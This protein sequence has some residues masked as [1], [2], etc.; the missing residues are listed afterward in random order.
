M[1]IVASRPTVDTTPRLIASNLVDPQSPSGVSDAGTQVFWIQ[2]VTGTAP[3]FLDGS[4]QVAAGS[5]ASWDS[6]KKGD[7]MLELEP[8]EQLWGVLAAAQ[9]TQ[10]LHVL[11]GGR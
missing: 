9:P 7:L 3:I 2:N 8:G 10:T 5:G 4:N 11:K 1:T 6:T